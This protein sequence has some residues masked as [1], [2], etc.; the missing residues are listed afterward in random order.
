M[1]RNKVTTLLVDYKDNISAAD[2]HPL[3][4][5]CHAPRIFS[6][7]QVL[8]PPLSKRSN[9]RGLLIPSRAFF[10]SSSSTSPHTPQPQPSQIPNKPSLQHQTRQ[11]NHITTPTH[12]TRQFF[13]RDERNSKIISRYCNNIS[14]YILHT[15]VYITISNVLYILFCQY[16]L[17]LNINPVFRHISIQIIKNN[18][19]SCYKAHEDYNKEK[20]IETK[21]MIIFFISPTTFQQQQ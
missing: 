7:G 4:S 13:S 12:H 18:I 9:L 17:I 15:S 21:V 1:N 6:F 8:L 19:N 3:L 2:H 16:Q 20:I 11:F 5:T 14:I 10:F